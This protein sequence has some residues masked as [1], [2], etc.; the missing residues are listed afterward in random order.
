MIDPT[1]VVR[2][3]LQDAASVAGL[4]ITTEAAVSELP[5]RQAG[6]GHGRRRHGRNGRNGLLS[7]PLSVSFGRAGGVCLRPFF[8]AQLIEHGFRFVQLIGLLGGRKRR[9]RVAAGR[10][11]ERQAQELAYLIRSKYHFGRQ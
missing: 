7:Q 10:Q 9:L 4:L 8:V 11:N 3:A 1:K 2:T 5:G 6:H